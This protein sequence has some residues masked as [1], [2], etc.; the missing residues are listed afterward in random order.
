MGNEQH[1]ADV[2]VVITGFNQGDMLADAVESALRQ[3]IGPASVIVVDD[4]STD[5]DSIAVLD[6]LGRRGD[7]GV[8]VIRQRNAG[9]SAARNAGIA[10]ADTTYISVLDGDDLLLPDFLNRTLAALRAAPSV[11]AASGWL[12]CFGILDCVVR[13][14]GGTLADFLPR[15]CCPSACTFRRETW[16]RCGG[17]DESM[18]EGFEDWEFCL[19]L[20]ETGGEGSR[21]EVVGE[22]LVNYRTAPVSSNVKSME[23]RTRLLGHIIERHRASYAAHVEQTVLALDALAGERLHL[24]ED[25]V[26]VHPEL[27]QHSMLTR[28]F[29]D[30]PTYGDGGMAA[31]VRINRAR[32]SAPQ[33]PPEP[34]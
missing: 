20:L 8:R 5:E 9:V 13:P 2:T 27:R 31:A 15:N 23:R 22:P 30:H 34:R 16:E 10:T 14:S 33:Y 11:V 17:Y 3:S 24:W 28:G 25:A 1:A 4:G 29:L 21:V 18:R 7:E 26:Q 12:K 19:S 6:A 32:C